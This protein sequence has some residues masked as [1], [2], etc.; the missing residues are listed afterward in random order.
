MGFCSNCGQSLTE[1]NVH[2]CAFVGA[3]SSSKGTVLKKVDFQ[4][5]LG[6]LRHPMN[7][8]Q[9]NSS[10]GGFIYGLIGIGMSVLG[11]F[12]FA[13]SLDRII[14]NSFGEF[15]F[16][17]ALM[18]QAS[19]GGRSLWIGLLSILAL[20]ASYW[21]VAQFVTKKKLDVK[22]F[23]AK[24]GSFHLIF[25]VIFMLSAIIAFISL[26]LA[27]IMLVVAILLALVC[28]NTL[29][30]QLYHA[31]ASQQMK[32]SAGAVGIYTIALMIIMKVVS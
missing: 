20:M 24:I 11:F 21:F 16:G 31:N 10:N 12:L 6:I 15:G 4:V 14:S 28:T 2:E 13:L 25:G 18:A 19:L 29:V 5:I 23:T 17:S 3:S 1:G 22:D 27:F 32:I 7:C 9:L 26:Q 8:V 30:L